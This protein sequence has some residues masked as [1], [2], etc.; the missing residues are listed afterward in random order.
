MGST[1][2]VFVVLIHRG[3]KMSKQCT[4]HFNT[5]DTGEVTH[6]KFCPE[7]PLFWTELRTFTVIWSLLLGAYELID[8]SVYKRKIDCS[9]C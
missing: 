9:D 2:F 4:S 5:L 8:I 3:P 7:N 1:G 6:N